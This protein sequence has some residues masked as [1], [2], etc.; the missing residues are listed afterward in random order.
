[1]YTNAQKIKSE[2]SPFI[3]FYTVFSDV[4]GSL[5]TVCNLNEIDIWIDDL[6]Q[7]I[8]KISDRK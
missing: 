2:M 8:E 4:G 1:M 5:V 7:E 3:V 6:S